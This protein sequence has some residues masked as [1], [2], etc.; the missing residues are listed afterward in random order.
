M[1][2]NCHILYVYAHIY[3][4][5]CIK[6]NMFIEILT[7]QF[8]LFILFL[9]SLIYFL[10]ASYEDFKKREVYNYINFSF[11]FIVLFWSVLVSL[12]FSN[13]NYLYLS[14]IGSIIGFFIG[15]ILFYLG[16]WGGGDAKFMIGFGAVFS[17]LSTHLYST[18]IH[19][20]NFNI[21][22]DVILIDIIDILILASYTF[23]CIS[24]LICLTLLV[25]L[26]LRRHY[27]HILKDCALLLLLLILQI[28]SLIDVFSIYVRVV[29][30][31]LA[32]IILFALPQTSFMMLGSFK[33]ITIKELEELVQ[34]GK[35][36]FFT[37]DIYYKN[38]R[39]FEFNSITS[40]ISQEHISKLKE[41]LKEDSVVEIVQPISI[42]L[43]IIL[44]FFTTILLFMT[45]S[46]F[47]TS[48]L[49]IH[50]LE[51]ILIS[52]LVG[53]AYI[54]LLV[55]YYV[56][57]HFSLCM[58]QIS[59][60]KKILYS[61]L[62]VLVLLFYIILPTTFSLISL[63]FGIII[64]SSIFYEFTKIVEKYLFVSRIKI[65]DLSPGDWIVEDVEVDNKVLFRKEE[66]KLGVN[67][68]QI[69]ILKRYNSKNKLKSV[70]V[71]SGIA[72]IPHLFVAYVIL[73]VL[74]V[75]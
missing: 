21:I 11:V 54:I 19:S 47:S 67:E 40:G 64:L 71:K 32:I 41:K 72:F 73:I 18:I 10:I 5:L 14:F 30:T 60:L 43:L 66:F 24:V 8:H 53:G 6:I 20:S 56:V 42:G 12:Y 27:T 46:L 16:T 22:L 1:N 62:L 44:N 13:L 70:L 25:T 65:N 31:I 34:K 28:I 39:V 57:T 35:I 36:C 59:S 15:S 3:K 29:T 49:F 45:S 37:K 48:S 75:L 51:F 33:N 61:I 9:I 4:K 68:E 17:Q 23:I 58:S 63:L 69:E 50:M 7:T 26:V 52:F 55:L 38:K 2:K 74:S